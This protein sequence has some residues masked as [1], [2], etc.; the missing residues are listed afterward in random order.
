MFKVQPS[1]LWQ[2]QFRLFP[3]ADLLYIRFM[4]IEEIAAEALRLPPRQR[5]QLAESLWE[6][7]SN[8]LDTSGQMDDGAAL[9]LARERDQQIEDGTVSPLL[10][11]EMMDR[12]RR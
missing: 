9:A 6:S 3:F 8:P 11:D 12:L 4:S 5:A 2:F 1:I 7:L 10:H